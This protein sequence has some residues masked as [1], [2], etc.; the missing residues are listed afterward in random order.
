MHLALNIVGLCVVRRSL[1][2][3]TVLIYDHY[4]GLRQERPPD[5]VMLGFP[6]LGDR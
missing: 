2:L 6:L 3:S 4:V 1:G 5:D